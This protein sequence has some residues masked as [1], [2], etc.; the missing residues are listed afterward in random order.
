M[1]E[2]PEVETIAQTLRR[3][4][5]SPP[6]PGQRI[7]GVTIRWSRHIAMPSVTTFRRRIRGRTIADVK[8]RGKYLVFPLD[9]GTMLI[10]LRMSG[11]LALVPADTP[12]GRY[13][14]TVFYLEDGQELRFSDARKFGKIFLLD[15]PDIILGKLG[16]EPLD[17]NFTPQILAS[18]LAKHRRAI[19]PLIMDQTFL[20]GLGN[21]YTDEALYHARI[22]PLRR[23]DSLDMNEITALWQGVRDAL[24]LGLHH[25]GASIDWVYRGGDFQHHFRVYQRA[26]EPC[27][28][29]GTLIERIIVGQRGTHYCPTCQG[30]VFA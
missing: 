21:I 10:H 17:I 28:R 29:C 3:G 20:A 2:L 27:H 9:R 26:G 6:L 14:R 8:R 25:S 4:N 18:R 5:G 19:K 11:D 22:H 7:T 1:P 12:S 15:D 30:E 16:P 13:D 23:S 24:K